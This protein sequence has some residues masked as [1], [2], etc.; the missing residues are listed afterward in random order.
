MRGREKGKEGNHMY[1]TFPSMRS[2]TFFHS[3]CFCPSV[4]ILLFSCHLFLTSPQCEYILLKSLVAKAPSMKSCLC[5][6]VCVCVSSCEFTGSEDYWYLRIS[7]IHAAPDTRNIQSS[8]CA[9]VYLCTA[10]RYV[11]VCEEIKS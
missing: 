8:A 1:K 4:S 10:N 9:G 5:M 6:C 7:S 2:L 11:C 3:C